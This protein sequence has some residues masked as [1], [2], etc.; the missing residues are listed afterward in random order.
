MNLKNYLLEYISSGRG[1]YS[2]YKENL[3]DD[4]RELIEFIEL[5][6]Y[7]KDYE[8]DVYTKD[9]VYFYRDSGGYPVNH[10]E[11]WLY[12]KN[13]AVGKEEILFIEF[14]IRNNKVSNISKFEIQSPGGTEEIN[15]KKA[16]EYLRM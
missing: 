1:K 4:F 13:P 5:L 8:F 14:E 2:R 11:K 16:L 6:G 3:P 12:A 15:L 7:K 10:N 9:K